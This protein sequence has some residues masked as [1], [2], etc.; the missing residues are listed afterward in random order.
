[1]NSRSDNGAALI[2]ACYLFTFLFCQFSLK[3]FEFDWYFLKPF[4]GAVENI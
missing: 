4:L 3:R 1:M 2:V